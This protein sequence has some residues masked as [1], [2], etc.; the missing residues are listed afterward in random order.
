M[1]PLDWKREHKV[2]GIA[3]CAVGAIAGIL[4]AWLDS[5]IREFSSHYVSGEW[6]NSTKFFLQWLA[7]VE[8]YWPWP[9]IGGCTVGL[10]FYAVQLTRHS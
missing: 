10:A 5:P 7:H 9:A 8:L 3:F 4:L 6:A 1:N 2:A